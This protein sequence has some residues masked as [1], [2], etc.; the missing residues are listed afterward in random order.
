M[1]GTSSA[2]TGNAG[3]RWVILLINFV[4]CAFAY[5]G[6]TTWSAAL[7]ELVDTFHVS[8]SVASLGASVFM[9]GY[10]VGS[11]VETQISARYGYRTGGLV[12][13]ICMVVGIFG[14]PY[15][16]SFEMVLLFRFLQGWG[17]LWVV[18][19]NSAVAW[20]PP[21]NRGFASGVIGASL[22]LGIGIGNFVAN[23]LMSITGTWQ[24]AFKLFAV[25]LAVAAAIWAVLMKNPPAG[26]YEE[27]TAVKN[28]S[29]DAGKASL[30]VNPYKSVGAWL[31]VACMFFNCWQLTGYLNFV[32]N[33]ADYLGYSTVQSGFI[34]LMAGLIGI[35]STPVG[36]II[37]DHLVKKGWEP[38]KA[39][40]F[41]MGVPGFL[42]AAVTTVLYPA[43]APVSYTLALVGCIL[44][45]WGVPIT[46]A[47]MGA[48]NMDILN[49]QTAADKMFA[50]TVLIGLG[51]GGSIASYIPTFIAETMSYTM[52]FVVMGCGA[53]AGAVISL[54]VP[55]FQIK[56]QG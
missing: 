26:L 3:Y 47:T 33:Y 37:S 23:G 16:P 8:K 22:V 20:F 46:N 49:D 41:T 9:M 40:C 29:A 52:S 48:I 5:S 2:K 6:L 34:S 19:T 28:T 1:M 38:I 17:I 56:N 21:E 43:M 11:F 36:G 7:N 32:G 39:R 18:G 35:V 42:I 50:F 44:C 10:A 31:L 14:V 55:R 51:L 27:D 53:L 24:G 54:V 25:V 30:R 13:L 12:G 45:G 4:V 15:A